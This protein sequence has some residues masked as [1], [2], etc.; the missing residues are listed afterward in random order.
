MCT[1][2]TGSFMF[3]RFNRSEMF[4]TK[5]NKS[6]VVDTTRSNYEAVVY[7]PSQIIQLLMYCQTVLSP[8]IYH[9]VTYFIFPCRPEDVKPLALTFGSKYP[10]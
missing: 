9:K 1:W 5:A 8:N 3:N 4:S 2:Y 7:P 10:V 6:L